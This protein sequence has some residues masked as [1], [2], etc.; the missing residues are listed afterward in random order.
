MAGGQ[1]GPAAPRGPPPPPPSARTG[2][3]CTHT[4]SLTHTTSL[5]SHPRTHSVVVGVPL[6]GHAHAAR[7]LRSVAHTHETRTGYRDDAEQRLTDSDSQAQ[8][9]PA[10]SRQAG[11]QAG[12]DRAHHHHHSPTQSASDGR[13]GV[14]WLVWVPAAGLAREALRG[15][16]SRL[17][18]HSLTHTPRAYSLSVPREHTRGRDAVS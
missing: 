8:A 3:W 10:G 6:R 14:G 7:G 12:P 1:H 5:A 15:L 4:H 13:G 11:R 9:G 2:G 16:A 18:T 17:P